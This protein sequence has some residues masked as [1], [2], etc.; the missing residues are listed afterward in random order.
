VDANVDPQRVCELVAKDK[1]IGNSHTVVTQERG[2]GGHCFPKD[3]SAIL[4]TA[5]LLGNDLSIVQEVQNYNND[6]REYHASRIHV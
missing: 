4:H 3:V 2:Y 1:R 5:E 6:V